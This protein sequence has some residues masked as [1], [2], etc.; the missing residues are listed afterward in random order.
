MK[1]LPARIVRFL[2]SGNFYNRHNRTGIGFNFAMH[3]ENACNQARSA[4]RAE[5]P[6]TFSF[7]AQGVLYSSPFPQQHNGTEPE[8]DPEHLVRPVRQVHW[9]RPR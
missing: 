1:L 9:N 2:S 3:P 7:A 4:N 8:D 5:N 6:R